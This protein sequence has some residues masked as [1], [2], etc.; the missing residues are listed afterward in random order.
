M[1]KDALSALQLREVGPAVAGGR[2]AD[3]KVDPT[4]SSVWYVAVGSGGLWKTANAGTTWTPVFDDQPS[5][6]IGT[7]AIDPTNPEVI[8]LG[9]AKSIC[10]RRCFSRFPSRGIRQ[11][12]SSGLTVRIM[13]PSAPYTPHD[14]GRCKP[15]VIT[16]NDAYP[17]HRT[18]RPS[19][20]G[21]R[22]SI[23]QQNHTCQ[24][25]RACCVS[26]GWPISYRAIVAKAAVTGRS[27]GPPPGH[28][29][30]YYYHWKREWSNRANRASAG[31][32]SHRR[33]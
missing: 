22:V 16:A 31:P 15:L 14:D 1:L 17:N 13:C 26:A 3:I 23:F 20:L 11:N 7:V 30:R 5:Y 2:I 12:T 18:I 8:W 9:T 25:C 19:A 33:P 10:T 6:S 21:I 27:D 29:T 4:N 24:Y 32:G 28:L